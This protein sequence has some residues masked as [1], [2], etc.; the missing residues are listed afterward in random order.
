MAAP[1]KERLREGLVRATEVAGRFRQ[2]VVGT[3]DVAI[4]ARLLLAVVLAFGLW[5][6]VTLR[7]NPEVTQTLR[8]RAVEVRGLASSAV[9]LTS[10]PLAEIVVSGPALLIEQTSRPITAYVDL[11]GRPPLSNQRIPVEVEMPRGVNLVSVTPGEVT[12]DLD[13]L[14]QQE[15]P[16][17][18]AVPTNLPADVR[19]DQPTL[20]P[21]AVTV[22][23]ARSTVAQ[24]ARVVVRPDLGGDP[25]DRTRVTRPIPLDIA[26]REVT[27]PRLEITPP[28]VRVTLPAL[29]VTGQKSVPIRPIVEGQPAA[30]YQLDSIWSTPTVVTVAGEAEALQGITALETE[31]ISIADRQQPLI[32]PVRLKLPPGV[33]AEQTMVQVEV[34]ISA[35]Q[36]KTR[37]TLVVVGRVGPGL[38]AQIGPPDTVDVTLQGPVPLIQAINVGALRA[39]VNLQGLGPGTYQLAPTP[40]GPGLD[41]LKVVE[42]QP[43]RINVLIA[44]LPTPTA[45]PTPTPTPAPAV[46]PTP[47]PSR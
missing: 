26:G 6:F 33:A 4:L 34:G 15:F 47:T 29:R 11:S 40:T 12:I 37:L 30:G 13:Q 41:R 23:G 22:S 1:S 25:A 14:V 24:I 36:A 20:E 8:P 43:A 19:M 31:P 9:V 46:T 42:I 32:Q 38:R 2:V 10:L 45:T 16:V 18:M 44:P 39:E 7:N 17:I 21:R 28:T 5:V 27:G 3:I 35:I